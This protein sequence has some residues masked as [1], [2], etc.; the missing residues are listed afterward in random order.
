MGTMPANHP[1]RCEW[2][3]IVRDHGWGEVAHQQ[4]RYY[5]GSFV[6]LD[7]Q[8]RTFVETWKA[9]MRVATSAGV[10]ENH[11][12][13]GTRADAFFSTDQ[14]AL[15]LAAM[16]S[17]TPQT[18]IGPEGMGWIPGGFTMYHSVGGKKPWRKKF[19]L[20]AFFGD[21]PWNGDKHFL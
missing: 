2:M 7:I 17:P 1:V 20:S 6:G 11:L 19:L 12:Q 15:N 18:T 8:H 10:D 13:H 14:D 21:A 5:N 3:E 16:Y 4:E 9:A